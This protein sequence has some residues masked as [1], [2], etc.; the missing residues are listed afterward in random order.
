MA[1]RNAA[2][3]PV[4]RGKLVTRHFAAPQVS[5]VFVAFSLLLASPFRRVIELRLLHSYRIWVSEPSVK[6][7]ALVMPTM[8]GRSMLVH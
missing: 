3:K 4:T 5:L 2:E 8:L 6:K 1:D 7:A